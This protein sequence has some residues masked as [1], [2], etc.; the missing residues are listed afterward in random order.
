MCE[1]HT[2]GKGDCDLL[3]F[4]EMGDSEYRQKSSNVILVN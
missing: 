1:I 2:F 4:I 3:N